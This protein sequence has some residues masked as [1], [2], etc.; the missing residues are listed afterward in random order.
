MIWSQGLSKL[1]VNMMVSLPP[2]SLPSSHLT[3]LGRR[4]IFVR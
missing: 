1:R 2:A 3:L 4:L